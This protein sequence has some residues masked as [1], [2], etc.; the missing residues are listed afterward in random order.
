MSAL[1]LGGLLQLLL[2]PAF[3]ALGLWQW[4]KAERKTALQAE[5][6]RR[7]RETAIALPATP[8][9]AETLRYRRVTLRGHYDAAH[10]VLIDNRLYREQAG[11]HVVTPL[12]LAG[13]AMVTLV[14]RGWLPAPAAHDQ[15]PPA[16]VPAGEIEVTGI[17]V[18]PPGRVFTLA[19]QPDTGWAAAWQ[20]LDLE[21]YRAVL[22]QP[23]QPV[24]VQLDPAAPGGFV[25][26]WP[27]PDERAE[28]HRSYALQWFGFALASL[29]IWGFCLL[30][31]PPPAERREAAP[32]KTRHP[33]GDERMARP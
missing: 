17:A 12:R 9:A 8:V 11:Y 7:S 29:G 27:R 4:D 22:G 6:D 14:N 28:R 26:D 15:L 1:L 16:P 23:L 24:V 32:P 5:L 18:E 31:R 30:R 3:V 2:V 20:N 10:Q 21:R 33:S 25:R 13:S 19:P